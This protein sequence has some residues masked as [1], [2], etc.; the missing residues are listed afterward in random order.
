MDQNGEVTVTLPDWFSSVNR[1]YRYQ[2][3]TIGS[4]AQ[5]YVAEEVNDNHFKIAG[6]SPGMKVSW[7]LT[8][9]RNDPY[10][11]NTDVKVEYDKPDNEKGTYLH[12]E[13]YNMP[14]EKGLMYRLTE[15]RK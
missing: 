8:A 1:D 9:L 2:L 12:P 15:G 10:M 11:Q 14:K 7:Q 3:T 5:V 4:Y 6:G 13:L